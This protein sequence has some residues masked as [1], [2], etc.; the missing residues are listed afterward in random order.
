LNRFNVKGKQAEYYA[1]SSI[2]G[3]GYEAFTTMTD[4]SRVDFVVL[5]KNTND[6]YKVQVKTTMKMHKGYLQFQLK[7]SSANNKYIY[8]KGDF[9][10]YAFVFVPTSEIMYLKFDDVLSTNCINF[11]LNKPKNNQIKKIN[12]WIPNTLKEVINV[13]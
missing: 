9:D 12:Y 5:D 13:F 1:I 2:I 11:R 7:K 3:E 4:N 8:K 6:L 10:I